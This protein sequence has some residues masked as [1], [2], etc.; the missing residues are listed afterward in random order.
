MYNDEDH[1]THLTMSAIFEDMRL[2]PPPLLVR[3]LRKFAARAPFGA[4]VIRSRDGMSPYLL[5]V[6][7]VPRVWKF[8]AVFLH[9]FFR[10]DDDVEHH[11]H[12]WDVA[13]SLVLVA[14]Y[15]E[16]RM[17]DDSW[18]Y[19][20]RARRLCPGMFNIVRRNDFH[21]ITVSGA[22]RRPWTLFVTSARIDEPDDEAWGFKHPGTGVY[23]PWRKHVNR[24][25]ARREVIHA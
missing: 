7:V 20:L 12:P 9:M 23:Q 6:V 5:R 17:V 13:C 15:R 1:V 25:R 3:A 14:G 11:N 4:R 16:E 22:Q 18:G 2:G 8:P 19:G 21:R 24:V 10:G